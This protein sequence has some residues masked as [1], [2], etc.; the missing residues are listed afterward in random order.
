MDTILCLRPGELA[1]RRPKPSKS[2]PPRDLSLS[3]NDNVLIRLFSLGSFGGKKQTSLPYSANTAPHALGKGT[4]ASR[5]IETSSL[6][7]SSKSAD[8][9]PEGSG[10]VLSSSSLE[11]SSSKVVSGG[12]R[13]ETWSSSR[14]RVLSCN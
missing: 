2:L 5:L 12:P 1:F 9:A 10:A 13:F 11:L 4:F 14:N 7:L 3:L 6:A 8:I